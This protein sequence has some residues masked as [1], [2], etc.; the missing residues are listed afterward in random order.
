MRLAEKVLSEY[1]KCPSAIAGYVFGSVGNGF[2]DEFSDLEIG[3]I[4]ESVPTEIVLRNIAESV[5]GISWRYDGFHEQK[6]SY[7]DQYTIDGLPVEPAHVAIEVI[8][9]VIREVTEDYDVSMNG[10]M[11]DRQA[12]LA[13]IQRAKVSF[14]QE[15]VNEI[16]SR[17]R[18]YPKRLSI[19]MVE[20]NLNVGNLQNLQMLAARRETHPCYSIIWLI[21]SITCMVFFTE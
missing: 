1:A 10:W 12:T 14:G 20:S 9:R 17:I 18:K 3:I 7:G 19:K 11:Y 4:W 15:I 13:T 8:D 16:R 5:G 6:L 21:G 2:A